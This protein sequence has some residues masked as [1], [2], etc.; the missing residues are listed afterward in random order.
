MELV[1]L[2]KLAAEKKASDLHLS[3]SEAPIL[4]IEGS[5]HRIDL[6]PIEHDVLKEMLESVMTDDQKT[7]FREELEIDYS[8]E[9]PNVSR[10][11]INAFHQ[12]RGVS[13]AFRRIPFELPTFE[14][15]DLSDIFRDFCSFP[16]GLILITGP[17][18]S[19]KST[20]LA[21]MINYMNNDASKKHHILTIEDPVEY[22]YKS[23]HCLIHQRE[24]GRDTLSFNNALR[25]ALR[26]DPDIIM[27]GEM[28]DL[29]TIRLALT[30]AETGHLV[31]ATMHTSS[32]AKTIDRI[33][34]AFPGGEKDFIRAAV[35]E[36]LRAVST[37][38]LVKKP[39]G[40]LRLAKEIMIC[41]PAIRNLIREHKI[42]QIYSAIQTGRDKGMCTL[43]Q[44]IEE[45]VAQN[46]AIPPEKSRFDS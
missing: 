25:S 27:I 17:T 28:R 1:E 16:N 4:R 32:A 15:L 34:D 26:E 18:G 29:E 9:L 23:N 21:A 43:E 37:Q 11:R 7:Q 33:I 44:S 3:T 24:A 40:G 31:L 10:F 35:A 36:S 45:L 12:H 6:P 20:T 13:G 30:A 22:V 14:S 41:T 39:G 2:L 46:L 5:L 8:Y 19:G 42:S 38:T